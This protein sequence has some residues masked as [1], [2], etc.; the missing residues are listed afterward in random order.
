MLPAET[1]HNLHEKAIF[2]DAV[3]YAESME[4]SSILPIYFGTLILV[5]EQLRDSVFKSANHSVLNQEEILTTL[6]YAPF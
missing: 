2:Q 4:A 5:L 6:R 3:T 1:E